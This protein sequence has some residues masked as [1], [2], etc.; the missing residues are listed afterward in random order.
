MNQ[1]LSNQVTSWREGRRFRAYELYQAGWK[2]QDIAAALGVTPGAVSQWLKRARE[3]GGMAALRRRPIPGPQ[4]RLTAEQR[5]KL[6][7]LLAQGAEAFGF[8]GQGW[9][10]PRVAALIQQQFG[11]RYHAT[12]AGRLLQQLGW[13]RQKPVV[14]ATQRQEEASQTWQPERWPAFQQTHRPQDEPRSA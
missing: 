14:R 4:A 13:T 9:T 1:T 11:V 5:A 6:P 3:E 10:H 7:T 12:H 2:Q 8:R